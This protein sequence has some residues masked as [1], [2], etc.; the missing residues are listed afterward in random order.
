[1]GPGTSWTLPNPRGFGCSPRAGDA[2]PALLAY[3]LCNSAALKACGVRCGETV[4]G[5]A[6]D[7]DKDGVA[8]GILREAAMEKFLKPLKYASTAEQD[9]D[10]L[11]RGME[12]FLRLGCT[13]VLTNDGQQVGGISH[14]WTLYRELAAAGKL[15]VRI[16]LTVDWK[17]LEK[18]DAG[19]EADPGSVPSP[20]KEGHFTM[21]RIKLW[22]DG[23]LGASTA[24]LEEPY[25]DDPMGQNRGIL[26]IEQTTIRHAVGPPSHEASVWRLTPSE[27]AQRES[28]WM[29]LRL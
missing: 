3:L 12:V 27:I 16:F 9:R 11:Q 8:T 13:S 14:P 7:V 23:A 26:Q 18:P 20:A 22:T 24:A 19:V 4:E 1:M 6:I 15:P 28:S 2:L 5:G 10:L 21:F 17:A 29:P 25:S